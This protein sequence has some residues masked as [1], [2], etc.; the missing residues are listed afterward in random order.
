MKNTLETRL[1]LFFALAMISAVLLLEMV[2]GLDAWRGGKDI[3]ARF[4][5]IQDLK[6]GDPVKLAGVQ[7]GRVATID[8]AEGQVEVTMKLDRR[9]E[10]S[11]RTD[12][13]AT[14]KFLGLMGQ[15]YIALTFGTKGSP[16][17]Q[18]AILTTVEQPDLSQLMTRLDNV[19][20]GI[21]SI[22]TSLSG[23]NLQNLLTP[24]TDFLKENKDRLSA[25]LANASNITA[26][27]A[28]G[29]G[30]VGKLIYDDTLH[31]SALATVTNFNQTAETA[32]AALEQV[33]S[34][35]SDLEAGRGTL[36]KLAT[37]DA[38]YKEAVVAVTNLREVLQKVN[39]GEGSVGKLVNDDTLF[40]NAK[41]TLQKLDKATE[42]LEDQGP[43]SVLGMA[44]GR[45]F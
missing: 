19:A 41:L 39:K 30:T 22:T 24:F 32:H 45:L 3:K 21:E 14:I 37:D 26:Q 17:E 28:S 33:R 23:D 42:S 35:I 16:V 15:N 10:S 9:H 27:V 36:G 12:S 34:L 38:L 18:G 20:K 7:V 29:E 6:V 44:V 1:G 13:T 4:A 25:I 11:V 43:L 31:Q 5:G 8:I 40:K 2:G